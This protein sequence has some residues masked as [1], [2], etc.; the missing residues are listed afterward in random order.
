MRIDAGGFGLHAATS[1][2]GAPA[3]VCL[4]GLVDT[5]EIWDPFVE[6]LAGRGCSLRYDQRGHGRS[7]APAGP[8]TREDL[9][10]D[11]R[12]VLDHEGIDRAIL[13][14]HSMGGV[15]AMEAA[16]KHPDRVI[17]LVLLGT[18]SRVGGKVAAWYERIAQAGEQEGLEG[19]RREIHGPRSQRMLQGDARGIAE[20]TRMLASLHDDPLGPKLSEIGCPALVVVGDKDPMGPRAS[21]IL[22][23]ELPNAELQVLQG[24]G[25]WVQVEAAGQLVSRLDAWLDGRVGIAE[26]GGAR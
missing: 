5:L 21:E 9:A 8:Y 25:H 20:V 22:S 7:D 26:R 23:E 2:R 1:G 15:V 6:A 12:A 19:I 17:G 10:R 24:C 18:T 4:H 13:V 14:G 16:L 11:T 3:L